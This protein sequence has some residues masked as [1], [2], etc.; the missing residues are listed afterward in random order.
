MFIKKI[1]PSAIK[2]LSDM[3]KYFENI[4]FMVHMILCI[5]IRFWN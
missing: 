1:F 5:L 4:I 2:T 3:I